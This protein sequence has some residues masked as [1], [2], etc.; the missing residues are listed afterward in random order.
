[1]DV[2]EQ[3]R[4]LVEP[5]KD[6]ASHHVTRGTHYPEWASDAHRDAAEN[7]LRIRQACQRAC[8][9]SQ[10]T[11]AEL[12]LVVETLLAEQQDID[13]EL[14][15]HLGWPVEPP[16]GVHRYDFCEWLAEHHAPSLTLDQCSTVL[17]YLLL[18]D[19]PFGT[20]WS[21]ERNQFAERI[22]RMAQVYSVDINEVVAAAAAERSSVLVDD[23]EED[24]DDHAQAEQDSTS[25]AAN[26]GD[27]NDHAESATE[28]DEVAA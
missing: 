17:V 22:Q 13:A 8:L 14:L 18:N 5:P 15:E 1:M 16:E 12:H 27:V 20:S 23:D 10:R 9:T 7:C 26:E 21:Q 28:G 11:P 25:T 6:D 19:A 24:D 2:L 4:A 3:V